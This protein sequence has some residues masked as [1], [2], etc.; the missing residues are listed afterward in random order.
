M[1]G[2]L[3]LDTETTG[4]SPD[5]G[6][7]LVEIAIVDSLGR[8]VFD[9][10]INPGIRIPR[11]AAD[12][13]GISDAMVRSKPR[14]EEVVPQLLKLV[15]GRE[16]VIYN[17]AYDIQFFPNK[18]SNAQ[19]IHCAMKSFSQ[20]IGQSRW[21]KLSDAAQRVGHVWEGAAHRALADAQACRSV[22]EWLERQNAVRRPSGVV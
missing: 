22:W 19:R 7:R 6:A 20:A 15:S 9:S 4:L 16:L 3:Y 11:E 10:L 1:S 21:V 8:T 5:R 17:A 18:L 14:F 13:H 12:I 2:F